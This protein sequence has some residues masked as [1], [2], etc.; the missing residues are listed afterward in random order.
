MTAIE[1]AS[2]NGHNTVVMVLIQAGA[3]V[4]TQDKVY[5]TNSFILE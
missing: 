2:M 5:Q 3:D 4:N 1:W